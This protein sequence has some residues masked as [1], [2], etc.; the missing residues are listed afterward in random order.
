MSKSRNS[1]AM[2]SD[3]N[4]SAMKQ[5]RAAGFPGS[6]GVTPLTLEELTYIAKCTHPVQSCLRQVKRKKRK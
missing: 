3:T 4:S 2:G 6:R 5:A 1:V